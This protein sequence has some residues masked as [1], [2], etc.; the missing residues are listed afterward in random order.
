MEFAALGVYDLAIAVAVIPRGSA[1]IC[2]FWVEYSVPRFVHN[3]NGN[4]SNISYL[5]LGVKT[6]KDTNV[7]ALYL[8]ISKACAVLVKGERQNFRPLHQRW[9]F[10]SWSGLGSFEPTAISLAIYLTLS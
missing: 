9:A 4:K 2:Y 3:N 6:V 5:K 10:G 1:L 8:V 7:Q